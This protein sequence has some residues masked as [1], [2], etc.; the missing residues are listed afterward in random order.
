MEPLDPISHGGSPRSPVPGPVDRE[1]FFEA[2]RRHRRAT[3]RLSAVCVGAVAVMGIPLSLV[4]TPVLYALVLLLAHL[5]DLLAPVPDG[6][7][8]ALAALASLVI[9]VIGGFLGEEAPAPLTETLAGLTAMLLP[10]AVAMVLI[11]LGLHPLFL[12][13]G[14][15]GVLLALGA[16]EPRDSDPEERE[17]VNVVEEM[18]VAAGLRPPHVMLLDSDVA[19]A[20][21]IG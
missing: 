9:R 19:N 15:G 1:S 3:W 7:W 20:A 5:V 17:L 6:F 10:G 2:Q 18:A 16:R 4:L 12:R 13:A 14:V 8:Q 21:A 11:W